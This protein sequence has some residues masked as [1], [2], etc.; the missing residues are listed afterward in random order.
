MLPSNV[1]RQH[2]AGVFEKWLSPDEPPAELDARSDFETL[3]G[4][5]SAA[6]VD[7]MSDSPRAQ[8]CILATTALRHG[9]QEAE[10][11]AALWSAADG[12]ADLLDTAVLARDRLAHLAELL[13]RQTKDAAHG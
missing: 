9:R 11:L 2:A 13:A 3:L 1:T 6:G 12:L 4:A 5:L 8:F 10:I 7:T